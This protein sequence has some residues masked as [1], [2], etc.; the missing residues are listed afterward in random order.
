MKLT[1]E[2]ILEYQEAFRKAYKK[3]ISYKDAEEEAQNLL[4]LFTIL[5]R[6]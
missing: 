6:K 5:I 1:E 3:E 2:A 4:T